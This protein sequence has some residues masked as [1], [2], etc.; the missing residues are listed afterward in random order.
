MLGLLSTDCRKRI[1]S[2]YGIM[3][4]ILQVRYK[5]EHS[6][7]GSAKL[8]ASQSFQQFLNFLPS[9][10]EY[11]VLVINRGTK[12]LNH[13]SSI[14]SC[15]KF[16]SIQACTSHF[17]GILAFCICPMVYKSSIPSLTKISVQISC[18]GHFG[19]ILA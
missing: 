12:R 16:R 8:N 6:L 18:T 13:L 14:P 7:S 5:Y 11:S 19:V 10:P 4:G 9:W 2:T 15:L 1:L 3:M 17:S